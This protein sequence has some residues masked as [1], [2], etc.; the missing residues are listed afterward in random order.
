MKII[1]VFLREGGEVDISIGEV[2]TLLGGN[3]AVVAAPNTDGLLIDDLQDI[4]GK[5]TIINVNDTA[6]LNDLCDVLVVDIPEAEV[7]S[8]GPDKE[9]WI[10]YE[11]DLHILS[12]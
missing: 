8:F 9:V 3:L 1:L 10:K 11:G 5:D 12:I 6:R 7:I 4:K 2:H